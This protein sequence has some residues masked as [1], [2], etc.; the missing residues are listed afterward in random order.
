MTWL[1]GTMTGGPI[2]VAFM[3]GMV[4]GDPVLSTPGNDA[5]VG[6]SNG[7][8]GG[9]GANGTITQR[10]TTAAAAP[11]SHSDAPIQPITT[12]NLPTTVA[13]SVIAGYI[14]NSSASNDHNATGKIVVKME[15]QR[16]KTKRASA[17]LYKKAWGF[18]FIFLKKQKTK[19]RCIFRRTFRRLAPTEWPLR[20]H[21]PPPN[22]TTF[23][24]T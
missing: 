21:F 24:L 6:S 4:L 7:G 8:S 9:G 18:D 3:V 2:V 5:Q 16:S 23:G 22:Y 19:K 20:G 11:P 14:H 10:R 1:L 13:G 17:T 15:P 12:S